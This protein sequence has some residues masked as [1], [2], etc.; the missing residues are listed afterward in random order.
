MDQGKHGSIEYGSENAPFFRCWLFTAQVMTSL[1]T[2]ELPT[3]SCMF[4]NRRH[5]TIL[6]SYCSTE[7][8]VT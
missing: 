2:A 3:P 5:A 1:P 8:V 4:H 6:S 7:Y